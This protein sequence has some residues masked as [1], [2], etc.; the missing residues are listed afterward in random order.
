MPSS[1][2][3]EHLMLLQLAR[4]K[5]EEITLGV[6][7]PDF[8]N[9][10]WVLLSLKIFLLETCMGAKRNIDAIQPNFDINM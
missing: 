7:K 5:A 2:V 4:N 3:T 1:V 10:F 6:G 8:K 9:A